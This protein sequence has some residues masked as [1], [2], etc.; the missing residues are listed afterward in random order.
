MHVNQDTLGSRPKCLKAAEEA[1][2]TGK[3]CVVGALSLLPSPC[4]GM[5]RP[6]P[7]NTNRDTATRKLYVAL[8][9]KVGVPAR[10][11]LFEGSMDLAW[12]NNLYR[13]YNQPPSNGTQV[14]NA[15]R[16]VVLWR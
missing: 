6:S 9:K 2:K 7:D 1:L 3:S 13:A 4:V 8:A 15:L 11:F 10:C 14:R 16:I 12:H 5:K